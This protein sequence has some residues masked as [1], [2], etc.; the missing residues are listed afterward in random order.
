VVEEEGMQPLASSSLEE[1]P[2]GRTTT[3]VFFWTVVVKS[4]LQR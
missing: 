1:K 4:N 3:R 2:T